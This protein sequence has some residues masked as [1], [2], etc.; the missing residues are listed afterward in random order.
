MEVLVKNCNSIDNAGVHIEEATLNIK[1]G[2]NG[3]GKSTISSAIQFKCSDVARLVELTPFKFQE[4]NPDNIVPEVSGIESIDSVAVFNESYIDQ[5]VFKQDELISNSFEIFVKNEEYN[6]KLEEI[7]K[8]V[9][10]IKDTFD[11]NQD[12]D[13]IISDLTELS[14]CFG[15]SKSGYSAASAIGKGL[16]KGN[17][18]ENI[19]EGLESYS[20][21]LKSEKNTKWIKWQITGNDFLEI[22]DNC[23]YCTSSTK[24]KHEQI[25]R[26]SKEFDAKSIEHLIRVLGVVERLEK[27]F[28]DDAKNNIYQITRNKIGISKAEITYL[29]QVKEQIDTLRDKFFTLKDITFFTFENVDKVIVKIQSLKINLNLL[30]LLNSENTK[31]IV[32]KLNKSL[33]DVL[34]KAGHLQGQVNMQ[35]EGI[36]KTIEERKEE[37]NNFLRYAGYKYS[38]EITDNSQEYKLKLLHHDCSQ[39]I[40]G[41]DQHL[42]Y[43]EKNAFSLVLFMYEC[44]S[45]SPSLIVLDDP[46]S[47]FDK[48]KKYA[49]LEMLFRGKYSLRGK[50]VLMF[51]HDLEPIIDMVKTQSHI[52]N[53]VP[54]AYFLTSR[55]GIVSE[56]PITKNDVKT[57]SQVCDE[58]IQSNDE[59]IIKLVYLRRQYETINDKGKEYQLI[60]N[61]LHKRDVP[62][63]WSG[64]EPVDMSQEDVCLAT[65]KILDRVPEFNYQRILEKINDISQMKN[66]YDQ[67][68]SGYEK[69]QIFRILNDAHDNNVV[70]KYIN[71]SFHI[72]NEYIS[73]LNP[74]K[75]ELIPEFIINECD[76]YFME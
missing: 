70:K 17:K 33:D 46:I 37:I 59:E 1:F 21:L 3:T 6:K 4:N 42:S 44:L 65:Q 15:K 39:A 58:N 30:P 76:E 41:G 19:P 13:L 38:V 32:E 63:D 20:Q 49:I 24:E 52:F 16:G 7:E 45:N 71:E 8:I 60:S 62:I 26:V 54:K 48:N 9:S 47:S 40:A 34:E 74:H 18:I 11:S 55:G 27:Y 56:L 51:T 31:R 64:E 22:S 28:S 36:R 69:L 5:F 25:R 75:Y 73:Q 2:V 29:K 12:I 53:P 68:F 14:E 50:T 66:I 57:F 43:G 23:P 67:C 10:S 35:K 61:L 72:E